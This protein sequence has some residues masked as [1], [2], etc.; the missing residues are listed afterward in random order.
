MHPTSPTKG[1]RVQGA[2]AQW[3]LPT[4]KSV[5]EFTDLTSTQHMIVLY[6]F[7]MWDDRF[8]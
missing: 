6:L 2:S 5:T 8:L 3:L 4:A 1:V 7:N